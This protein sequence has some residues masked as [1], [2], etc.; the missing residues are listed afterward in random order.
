MMKVKVKREEV[1]LRGDPT[2]SRTVASIK[3][4][5]KEWR[6]GGEA[7]Y[8]ELVM[9]TLCSKEMPSDD[10]DEGY[11]PVRSFGAIA[12]NTGS[13]KNKFIEDRDP[14]FMSNFWKELFNMARTKLRFSTTNDP[15]ID[16]KTEVFYQW[17]SQA[18]DEMVDMSPF[19]ALYGREPPTMIKYSQEGTIVQEIDQLLKERDT[20]LEE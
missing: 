1:E 20:I 13:I 9:I 15:Q 3:T 2:L 18:V 8:I 6:K 11:Q 4:M 5:M 7:Y 17:I 16:G 12:N 10:Q 19:R 14:V